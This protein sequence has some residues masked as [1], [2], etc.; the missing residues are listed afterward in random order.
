MHLNEID[1]RLE[2]LNR[3]YLNTKAPDL[4]DKSSVA[5]LSL[6]QTILAFGRAARN[7]VL[8]GSAFA[9]LMDSDTVLVPISDKARIELAWFW[10]S[11]KA[12]KRLLDLI[13]AIP[14]E[15]R[16]RLPAHIM[17]LGFI[18]FLRLQK[19]VFIKGTDR[20][21]FERSAERYL[22]FFAASWPE[23][24][25]RI[26][27]Y[28]LLA[29]H[30]VGR[31]EEVQR[32][33]ADRFIHINF[34]GPLGGV[35]SILSATANTSMVLEPDIRPAT[36]KAVTL[37][38]LNEDYFRR[39]AKTFMESHKRVWPNRAIHL[40]CVGFDPELSSEN[41]GVTIDRCDLSAFHE[42]QKRGYFAAARYLHL[43]RYLTRYEEI[44]V[45]DVDG[46]MVRPADPVAG[47]VVLWTK[48]LEPERVLFKLPWEAVSAANFLIRNTNGG[49]RSM[50]MPYP[51]TLEPF[52]FQPQTAPRSGLPT[53]TPC[54]TL[55]CGSGMRSSSPPFFG[56]P[57]AK[58]KL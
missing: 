2:A 18:A 36:S 21:T 57:F 8:L 28:S 47:D 7:K 26:E 11:Q 35:R 53:K 40:H 38:S 34:A 50:R 58:P 6:D 25:E 4:V 14:A 39:Y 41:I 48:V 37:I 54:S 46:T 31:L 32:Q 49:R 15:A 12:W 5:E 52:K 33:L 43:P 22:G 17:D 10:F 45:T 44:F 23:Q 51:I 19:P 13:G 9:M 29:R 55:G 42:R 20:A 56:Q 16:G 3:C 24:K 1:Q 30:I 27:V